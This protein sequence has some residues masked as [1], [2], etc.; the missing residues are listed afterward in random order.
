MRVYVLNAD[1][2]HYLGAFFPDRAKA[3]G[4]L[5]LTVSTKKFCY[6]H[7]PMLYM[8]ASVPNLRVQDFLEYYPNRTLNMKLINAISTFE[9][10]CSGD[11]R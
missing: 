5:M 4:T 11:V 2:D 1:A 7:A 8:A 6:K 3:R 9:R 10:T